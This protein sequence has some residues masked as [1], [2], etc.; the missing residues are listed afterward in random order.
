MSFDSRR[1]FLTSTFQTGWADFLPTGYENRPFSQP[2]GQ[3]WAR[4]SVRESSR[5]A[6]TVGREETRVTGILYLQ[7]FTPENAGTK[8][9]REA[10]AKMSSIFDHRSMIGGGGEFTMRAVNLTPV[11]R[12]PGGYYQMNATCEF[13]CDERNTSITGDLTSITADAT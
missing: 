8:K 6:S 11:G 4:F 1:E 9:A 3:P 10:A 5:G 13:W 7:I 12:E 2:T